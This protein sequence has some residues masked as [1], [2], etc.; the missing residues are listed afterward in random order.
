MGERSRK[1][2]ER[3]RDPFTVSKYILTKEKQHS[4]VVSEEP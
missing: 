2:G 4:K 1:E 3:L